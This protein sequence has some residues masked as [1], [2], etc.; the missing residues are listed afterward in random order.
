MTKIMHRPITVHDLQKL[1]YP[2][3]RGSAY[4]PKNVVP[5]KGASLIQVRRRL[6]KIKGS[7]AHTIATIREHEG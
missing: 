4:I 2:L 7:L 3:I 6:A 5:K 1:G